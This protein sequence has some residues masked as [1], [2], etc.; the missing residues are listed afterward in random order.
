MYSPVGCAAT[1]SIGCASLSPNFDRKK[2]KEKNQHN[3]KKKKILR[4]SRVEKR[5]PCDN[6]N[7]VRTQKNSCDH[8]NR[9]RELGNPI[10]RAPTIKRELCALQIDCSGNPILSF[11]PEDTILY[12]KYSNIER[13]GGYI[14]GK[15]GDDD[16]FIL[17][18]Q[19]NRCVVVRPVT[20]T[21]VVTSKKRHFQPHIK[22]RG[23]T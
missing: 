23:R 3:K 16:V 2:E 18:Q 9:I 11:R 19:Q 20:T 8:T 21:V 15:T 13:E 22:E 12:L 14:Y 7:V 1:L 10:S 6:K 17:I 4:E 5:A